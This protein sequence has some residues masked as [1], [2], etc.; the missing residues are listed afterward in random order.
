M[1]V[2]DDVL[3]TPP[4]S[5]SI[6]DGV[7]RDS[8]LTIARDMGIRVQERPVSVDEIISAFEQNKITEVF[9]AGTAAVVAP[10]DTVGIDGVDY[11]L[12]AY[13]DNN[14]MFRVKKKLEAMRNG[15]EEDIYNWNSIV[16]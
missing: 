5:D 12:P 2:I 1:F 3:L 15:T 14:I 6:L 9:G 13:N 8:L 10:I 16:G 4:I 7:T 11:K